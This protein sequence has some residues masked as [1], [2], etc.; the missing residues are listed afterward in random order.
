MA[1]TGSAPCNMPAYRPYW[2]DLNIYHQYCE[3]Q[4][5]ERIAIAIHTSRFGF[6]P[7]DNPTLLVG[8]VAEDVMQIDREPIQVTDVQRTKVGKEGIVQQQVVDG[9]VDGGEIVAVRLG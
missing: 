5:R 4:Y 9:E 3:C 1:T 2:L 8:G 6:A 7:E